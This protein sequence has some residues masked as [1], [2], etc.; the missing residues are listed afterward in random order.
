MDTAY[1]SA[2][3]ALAGSVIGGLT[4]LTAS[5][6]SQQAQSRGEQRAHDI[7]R[8]EELFRGFM[9]EASSVTRNARRAG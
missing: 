3:S 5:W 6:M 9:E 2:F 1:I 7:T 4:S 8:R